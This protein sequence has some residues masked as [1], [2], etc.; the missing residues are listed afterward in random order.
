MAAILTAETTTKV[1]V[2]V[3]DAGL[4]YVTTYGGGYVD[5]RCLNH[6]EMGQA[7]DTEFKSLRDALCGPA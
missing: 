1:E 6:P 5:T 7:R 4:V 3:T 2:T